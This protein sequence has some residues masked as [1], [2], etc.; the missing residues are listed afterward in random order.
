MGHMGG[1]IN[2]RPGRRQYRA[3]FS[4]TG[5]SP[6]LRKR[7]PCQKKD[8]VHLS[9]LISFTLGKK[10]LSSSVPKC[11]S[12]SCSPHT[13]EAQVCMPGTTSGLMPYTYLR[14]YTDVLSISIVRTLRMQ[15]RRIVY[16]LRV[17]QP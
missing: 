2:H 10:Y 6:K 7:A 16:L 12:S 15:D 4:N 14:T 8:L 13:Y 5:G 11:L 1:L 3:G 9:C 17:Q